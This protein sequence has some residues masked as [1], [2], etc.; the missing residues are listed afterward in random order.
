MQKVLW[1]KPSHKPK[2]GFKTS[3]AGIIR[4]IVNTIGWT[5]CKEDIKKSPMKYTVPEKSGNE[6]EQFEIN[7]C[8]SELILPI[9][10]VNTSPDA[11]NQQSCF[12]SY[13]CIA[14]VGRPI[15]VPGNVFRIQSGL[16]GG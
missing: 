10:V 9:I 4:N 14:N 11:C 7:L 6:F 12:G 15:E 8:I 3:M 13:T 5:M 16:D 2:K 1:F